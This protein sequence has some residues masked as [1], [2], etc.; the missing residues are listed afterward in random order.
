MREL[1]ARLLAA[2]SELLAA[3]QASVKTHKGWWAGGGGAA[4]VAIAAVVI[5]FG[6]FLGP[7]GKDICTV[8]L[9]HAR[10]YGVLPGSATLASTTAKSTDERNRRLCT[11]KV[12]DDIYNITADVI[13][14]DTADLKC[15]SKDVTKNKNC[16]ALYSVAREDGLTTYQVRQVPDDDADVPA[17]AVDAGGEAQPAL[18]DSDIQPTTGTRS[19]NNGQQQ[20]AAPPQ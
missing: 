18:D 15:K 12:G 3:V 14:T 7:S 4:A 17:V 16:I 13:R 6:G 10:E 8:A 1:I 19:E 11:A 5:L 9:E 20:G 2:S